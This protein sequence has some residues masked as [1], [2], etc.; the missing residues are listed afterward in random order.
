MYNLSA[1][2]FPKIRISRLLP[3]SVKDTGHIFFNNLKCDLLALQ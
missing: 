3:F 1:Y 2:N